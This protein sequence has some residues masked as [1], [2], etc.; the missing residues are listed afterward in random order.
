MVREFKDNHTSHIFDV[1]FNVSRI[2]RCAALQPSHILVEML[3]LSSHSTSHDQKIVV[4]DFTR[5][6]ESTSLFV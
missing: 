4:I 6:I 5:G 3:T 2:V 1:K